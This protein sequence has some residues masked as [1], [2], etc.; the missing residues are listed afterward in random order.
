MKRAVWGYLLFGNIIA[1][2]TRRLSRTPCLLFGACIQ[3]HTPPADPRALPCFESG[4]HQ[5][6]LTSRQ[7]TAELSTGLPYSQCIQLNPPLSRWIPSYSACWIRAALSWASA[8]GGDAFGLSDL[9]LLSS[10]PSCLHPFFDFAISAPRVLTF[11]FFL[12]TFPWMHLQQYL[13]HS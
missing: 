10:L 9:S 5:N 3:S 2:F 13:F 11:V 8:A 7:S 4:L 6:R 1:S 12:H